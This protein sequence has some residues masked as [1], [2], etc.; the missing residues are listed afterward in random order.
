MFPRWAECKHR[1]A[2]EPHGWSLTSNGIK[3]YPPLSPH[4]TKDRWGGSPVHLGC[5]GYRRSIPTDSCRKAKKLSALGRRKQFACWHASYPPV[6][7]SPPP[8]VI[9]TTIAE[10][11][12]SEKPRG[13]RFIQ[14]ACRSG[15]VRVQC[16]MIGMFATYRDAMTPQPPPS[17]TTPAFRSWRPPHQIGVNG[18]NPNAERK[19]RSNRP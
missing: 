17:P 3:V 10:E 14:M 8:V 19:S 15:G 11:H 2:S 12:P 9:G 4:N 7:G 18:V 1:V 6:R 5:G 16:S 13:P